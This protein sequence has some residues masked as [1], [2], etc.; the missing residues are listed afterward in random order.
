[1]SV[2][3]FHLFRYLD[4]R[5]FAYNRRDL[6]DYGRFSLVVRA[7]AGRRLTYAKLIGKA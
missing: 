7:V 3:P 1:V 6:D 5:L 4:E 2:E